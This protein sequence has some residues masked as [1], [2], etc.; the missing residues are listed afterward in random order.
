MN[1]QQN[2]IIIGAGAF[3]EVAYEYF[4]HDSNYRVVAFSV[5]RSFI[6]QETLFDLPVVPFEELEQRFSPDTHSFFVAIT[7]F[8]LNKVRATLYRQAKEKGYAPASYIS[9]HAFVWQNATIGEHCFI[10][11]KSVVQPFAS[12]GNNVIMWTGNFVGHHSTVGDHCFL[13]AHSAINGTVN[14]GAFTF[15]GSNATVANHVNIGSH[16]IISAGGLILSDVEDGQVVIGTWRKKTLTS[17]SRL[18]TEFFLD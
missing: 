18:N 11:E 13:G 1:K 3:A 17:S 8:K 12:V 5:E 16:S 9:S 2:L 6:R 10:F 4:T 7:Y 14:L 15:L